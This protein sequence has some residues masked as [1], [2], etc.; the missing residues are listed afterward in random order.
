MRL[1]RCLALRLA[2]DTKR[3]SQMRLKDCPCGP[4]LESVASVL[5]FA[6]Q[7]G[8]NT[9]TE[10]ETGGSQFHFEKPSHL[11]LVLMAAFMVLGCVRSPET[12]VS[13]NDTTVTSKKT[14]P[15]EP[16]SNEANSNDQATIFANKL[17]EAIV[18]GNSRAVAQ[19]IAWPEIVARAIEPFDIDKTDKSDLARDV[20]GG[21]PQVT[22]GISNAIRRG[23]NYQLLH[24][25]QRGDNPFALFRLLASDGTLNYHL[26]RIKK[27]RGRLRVDQ[28]FSAARAGEMAEALRS[29]IVKSAKNFTPAGKATEQQK[30]LIEDLE[31]EQ[32]MSNAVAFGFEEEA[33]K[34]YDQLPDRLKVSRIPMLSRIRAIPETDKQA[35]L[36][37][38]KE[39]LKRFPRDPAGGLIAIDVGATNEDIDILQQGHRILT[40]WTGGDPYLD[41]LVGANLSR[42]GEQDLALKLTESVDPSSV[43]LLGAHTFK[44]HISL[45]AG[46]H[47]DV[48]TQLRILRDE[49]GIP[50]TDLKQVEHFR[51]FIESPEYEQWLSTNNGKTTE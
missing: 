45:A 37:A 39:Y 25:K 30:G 3:D 28:F 38:V 49:Y 23:S 1:P 46:D 8:R 42:L 18:A 40:E 35:Y 5:S 31:I 22:N 12:I 21:T 36:T 19:M 34:L 4:K 20:L 10:P 14:E 43:G 15:D 7:L 9:V 24:I 51:N 44:L 17:G 41:L 2:I 13:D 6:Y 27:I 48:F 32:R 29:G 33:L 11:F 47:A 16:V 50:F 26:L